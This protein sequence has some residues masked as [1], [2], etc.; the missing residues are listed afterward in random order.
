MII[1]TIFLFKPNIILFIF[2]I[3]LL[4]LLFIYEIIN[5]YGDKKLY[6]KSYNNIVDL[7]IIILS[8]YTLI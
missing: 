2:N 1:F 4:I 6:F 8:S 3:I 7:I 5:Y